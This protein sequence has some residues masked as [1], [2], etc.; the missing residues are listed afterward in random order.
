MEFHI[1]RVYIGINI[2]LSDNIPWHFCAA[3]R[4]KCRLY[5]L[6]PM[7]GRLMINQL[8]M[9]VCAIDGRRRARPPI[10]RKLGASTCLPEGLHY[11]PGAVAWRGIMVV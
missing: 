2:M 8:K 6:K 10:S 9:R 3:A 1:V 11:A 5:I 7:P 4:K